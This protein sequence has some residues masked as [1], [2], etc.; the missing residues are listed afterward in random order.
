MQLDTHYVSRDVKAAMQ[1]DCRNDNRKVH[2]DIIVVDENCNNAS[3]DLSRI[4]ANTFYTIS[5]LIGL[6]IAITRDIDRNIW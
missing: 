5:L 2:Y 4:F 3:A 6:A 1:N